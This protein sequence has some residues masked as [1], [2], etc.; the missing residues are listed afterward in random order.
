VSR[1]RVIGLLW[2]ESSADAARRL[3]SES[4]YVLRKELGDS[5]I[6]VSGDEIRLNPEALPSDVAEFRHAMTEG[7]L[8][9][10]IDLYG[11]PFLDAWYVDDAAEFERWVEREREALA[12]A[13]G[14]CLLQL[15]D[16]A[17]S[18]GDWPMAVRWCR[19][20]SE[21]DR[22]SARFAIR[23]AQAQV[24]AGQRAAALQTLSG[25]E[26]AL[27]DEMDL[28]PEPAVVA[29]V[30]QLRT[31]ADQQVISRTGRP[32]SS[33]TLLPGAGVASE[34]SSAVPAADERRRVW[35]PSVL[36]TATVLAVGIG[37]AAHASR[38]HE[39][40]AIFLPQFDPNDVAVRPFVD[41]T[42]KNA[43]MA[44]AL[45]DELILRLT[46]VA[47]I[48][49]ASRN[50]VLRTQDST[51]GID[52][53]ARA[54][55]VGT[56]IEGTVRESGGKVSVVVLVTDVGTGRYVGATEVTS[57]SG[58]YFGLVDNLATHVE[59]DFRRRIGENFRLRELTR[60]T[61]S[62]DATRLMAEAQRAIDLG[63]ETSREWRADAVQ[64]S[65]GYLVAAD[66][67]LRLAQEADSRWSLP[68]VRRALVASR[69]AAT[70]SG[71]LA[72]RTLDA[73][74][75]L[76]DRALTVDPPSAAALELRGSLRF[77]RYLT[78]ASGDTSNR[79]IR[80]AT[81]DFESA[82]SRDSLRVG[83]WVGRAFI[84]WFTL[85]TVAARRNLDGAARLDA[86]LD[87]QTDILLNKF[88]VAL[89]LRDWKTAADACRA[90]RRLDPWSFEFLQ[91]QLT[92]ARHDTASRASPAWASAIADTLLRMY[93]EEKAA[94]SSRP[95]YPIYWRVLAATIAARA[96]RTR[97]ART[98]MDS[99]V[100]HAARS[101]VSMDL[102]P[103][104]AYFEWALGDT[105]RAVSL[106]TEYLTAR[107]QQRANMRADALLGPIIARVSLK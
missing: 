18:G 101:G 95:Y 48:R 73:G 38:G 104:R 97:E 90:G 4:L 65:R 64:V 41:L 80:L 34:S 88:L 105:V 5:V 1:E 70:D 84:G 17:E 76:L 21:T 51:I 8:E 50:A 53:L 15:A 69:L 67:I 103:D 7:D 56:I 24:S 94:A 16:R 31:S 3:L 78:Y 6:I 37:L 10:A 43:S 44:Y 89:W 14:E 22:Y 87:G 23:L 55:H 12:R 71:R 86:Y 26:T 57:D 20:L 52:S 79:D 36:A 98:E 42:G 68:L 25:Y 47:P 85:D 40:A 72:V 77:Q 29:Y 99:A 39:P 61:Q 102:A 63:R 19:E 35:W 106:M 83:A 54:L 66:S 75:A 49:V 33:P 93:P 27:R 91:C 45:T 74:I 81:A 11:G 82:K 32:H 92:L 9:R 28:P 62:A 96:G 58:G 60:G 2:P 107:K 46:G 30:A 13:F 59:L 100:V